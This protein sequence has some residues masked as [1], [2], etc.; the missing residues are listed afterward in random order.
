M[1]RFWTREVAGWLLVLLGL[2]GFYV[3]FVML[4]ER[5]IVQ[6]SFMTFISVMV[7]RGGIHLVKVAVAAR[8]CMQ[9]H[10]RLAQETS[11]A[12]ATLPPARAGHRPVVGSRTKQL[13]A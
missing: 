10:E 1:L 11:P 9:A 7:F 2:F 8:I 6:S 3:C 13:G 12:A 5:Q 4:M